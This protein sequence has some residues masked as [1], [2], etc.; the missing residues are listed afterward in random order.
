VFVVAAAHSLRG[1]ATQEAACKK[2][3]NTEG[4]ARWLICVYMRGEIWNELFPEKKT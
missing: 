2:S 4:L 3:T 1:S